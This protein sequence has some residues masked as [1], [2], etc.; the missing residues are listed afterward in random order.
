[1][2]VKQFIQINIQK[3]STNLYKRLSENTNISE[4]NIADVKEENKTCKK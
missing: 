3:K 1:M 2:K 4:T